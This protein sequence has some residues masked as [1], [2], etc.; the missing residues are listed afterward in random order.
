MATVHGPQ[1]T[2]AVSRTLLFLLLKVTE[3]TLVGLVNLTK[4][5]KPKLMGSTL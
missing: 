2:V 3:K 5:I 1:F 4:K